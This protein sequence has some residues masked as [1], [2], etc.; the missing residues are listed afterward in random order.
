MGTHKK[1]L[2]V[3]SAVNFTE[4]G[5]RSVLKDCLEAGIRR[6]GDHYRI[7]ALV[8]KMN[9]Y[10]TLPGVEYHEFPLSKSSWLLRLAYEFIYFR[11]LSKRWKPD[12][13]LS[14]H[15]ISPNV[16]AE[17]RAVYCHNPSPFYRP[18]LRQALLEPIFWLFSRFYYLLYRINIKKNDLVIV[19]QNWMRN[20]FME[21]Y[22]IDNI[23]V[24]HPTVEIDVS[25]YPA[26]ERNDQRYKFIFPAYPRVFKNFEVIVDAAA[27]LEREGFTGF[28]II[29]TFTGDETRYARYIKDRCGEMENIRFI[30]P[31]SRESIFQL[32]KESDCLIFPSMLETWGLPL[33]EFK[34][35]SKPL[36][37]ADLPYAHE[38]VG[39]YAQVKYFDPGSPALLAM[40]MRQ[41][42]ENRLQFDKNPVPIPEKP[43]VEGWGALFDMLLEP[44][45]SE[46]K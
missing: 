6:I 40:L 37:A 13:W 11:I 4:G 42:A 34:K 8:H 18:N 12:V 36:L 10:S 45:R 21:L 41:I 9:L 31:Q 17:K 2:I 23:V 5:P 27:R 33:T 28:E 29:F 46:K 25:L 16:I 14:L 35:F 38:T 32:Y 30:G 19:Q 39:E 7:I 26:R 20:R 22:G 15:D 3:I 44:S 43:Y 1:K 24:A